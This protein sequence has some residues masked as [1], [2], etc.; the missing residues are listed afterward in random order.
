MQQIWYVGQGQRERN[1]VTIIILYCFISKK[2]YNLEKSLKFTILNIFLLIYYENIIISLR[3]NVYYLPE[4]GF[5]IILN[6]KYGRCNFHSCNFLILI[7]PASLS[8]WVFS[9]IT[10]NF[11]KPVFHSTGSRMSEMSTFTESSITLERSQVL[12]MPVERVL[13]MLTHWNVCI[14][15]SLCSLLLTNSSL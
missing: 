10:K 4:P 14:R 8:L 11:V 2:K 3:T 9:K 13:S 1:H 7:W 15:P 12:L 6:K 5:T